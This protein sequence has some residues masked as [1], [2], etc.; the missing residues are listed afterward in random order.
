M[1]PWARHLPLEAAELF[2]GELVRAYR[3]E[4]SPEAI[5]A[6]VASWRST[7]E[8]YADPE[9]LK[10]LRTPSEGDFGPVPPPAGE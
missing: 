8:V 5:A 2:A 3:N 6:L 4:E 7:A 10:A 9:L 1:F